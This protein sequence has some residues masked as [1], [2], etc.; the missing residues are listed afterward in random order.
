M[1]RVFVCSPYR[2]AVA[3]NIDI[4]QAICRE[5]ALA[6]DAPLAPHL[7]YPTFLDDDDEVERATGIAASIT[8]LAVADL[9]LV[10]GTP[11]AGMEREIAAARSL[12]IPIERV[13]SRDG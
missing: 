5:I 2:G 1:R 7:L 8:W 6:G 12:G 11:T 4:A 9:V 13:P 10:V 3:R